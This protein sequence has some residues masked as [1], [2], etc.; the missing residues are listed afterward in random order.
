MK[1]SRTAYK[2]ISV[3]AVK[4]VLRTHFS[5][6]SISPEQKVIVNRLPAHPYDFNTHYIQEC[7]GLL[8][9]QVKSLAGI[10]PGIP[11]DQLLFPLPEQ[12]GGAVLRQS[13]VY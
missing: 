3:Q 13:H 11:V 1:Y 9:D 2:N 7:I 8:N 12:G 6:K 4:K 5:L 10:F